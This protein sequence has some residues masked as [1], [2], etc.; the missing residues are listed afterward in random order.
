MAIVPATSVRGRQRESVALRCLPTSSNARRRYSPDGRKVSHFTGFCGSR[1][2]TAVTPTD[3]LGVPWNPELHATSA[4]TGRGVKT[5]KGVWRKRK[6]LKGTESRIGAGASSSAPKAD[7]AEVA[8]SNSEL[9]ARKG[10]EM[11]AT[12]MIRISC[13]IG[14]ES[15]IPKVIE[16]PGGIK[17][18][19]HEM[20][21]G[22]FGDYF[23]ATGKGDLP[24]GWALLGALCMYYLPR[25]QEPQV[26]ARVGGIAGWF[27]DKTERAFIWWKYRKTTNRTDKDLARAAKERAGATNAEPVK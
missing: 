2:V 14:G 13:G 27:K 18:N 26:K 9:Q 10:G 3:I 21:S 4:T 11:M 19:E 20:L 12:L 1:A 5:A 6:G 24:P 16:A 15:F 8:R 23:V 22:A 7:P 25:L 17:F